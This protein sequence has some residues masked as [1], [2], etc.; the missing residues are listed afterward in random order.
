M[1][2]QHVLSGLPMEQKIGGIL[3]RF[4]GWSDGSALT[5]SFTTAAAIGSYTANYEPVTGT[6]PSGW[7]STDVG[8]PIFAGKADYSTSSQSFYVDGAGVDVYGANDQFHYVYQTLN[9]DGTIV[10]RVR[11]QT[12]TSSSAKAGLMI[13][14]SA[15]AGARYGIRLMAAMHHSSQSHQLSATACVCSTLPVAPVAVNR[16]PLLQLSPVIAHPTNGSSCSE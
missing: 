10:A 4:K 3:Y 13:K 6:M 1:G 7:Q 9:G 16:S 12:N 8:S 5:D 14:Q 11:Y 15:T 2:I